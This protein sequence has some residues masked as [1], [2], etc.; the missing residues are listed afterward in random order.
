MRSAAFGL[1]LCLTTA[2]GPCFADDLQ[3]T[4]KFGATDISFDLKAP[5][6]YLTL[7]VS[8]PNGLQTSAAAANVSPIVDLRRLS[9]IDDG[10]YRYSLTGSTG[11]KLPDRSGLDN[12]RGKPSDV[13]L[14]TV[15][16]SGMFEVRGGAIVKV[17]P[18][19]REPSNKRAN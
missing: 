18:A 7:T 9:A 1:A 5:Y 4:P 12:G 10:V 14:R 11:E 2:V 13:R 8:G 19:V 17:D 15:S 6:V 16:T 3:A